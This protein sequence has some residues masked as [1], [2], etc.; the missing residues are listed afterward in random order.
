VQSVHPTAEGVFTHEEL[1]RT[2]QPKET[3]TARFNNWKA[4][5][6]NNANR[7]C[8]PNIL[9]LPDPNAMDLSPGRARLA[10]AEDYEPGGNQYQPTGQGFAQQAG[11]R[12]VLTCFNCSKP[13]HFKRDCRQPI[14]QNTY[15]QGQGPL[16]TRQME[17]E[18][19]PTCY[20][21]LT[22]C[23]YY[24]DYHRDRHLY[25]V[26]LSLMH[27]LYSLLLTHLT[28]IMTCSYYRYY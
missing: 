12:K 8:Q 22:N 2:I 11:Q 27:R 5:N 23:A 3:T 13:G 9:N 19:E 14:K 7:W 1:T 21:F 16:C 18:P 6:Y 28:P 26:I 17:A 15:N 20:V 25:F 4:N 24:T 10:Q